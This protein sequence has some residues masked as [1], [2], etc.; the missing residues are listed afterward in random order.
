[1]LLQFHSLDWQLQEVVVAFDICCV[2]HEKDQQIRR[3]VDKLVR[4][5]LK[6]DLVA[7]PMTFYLDH[8]LTSFGLVFNEGV[9]I[10]LVHADIPHFRVKIWIINYHKIVQSFC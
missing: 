9:N 3:D 4:G 2:V 6:S 5:H 7:T 1:M 10:F 8:F